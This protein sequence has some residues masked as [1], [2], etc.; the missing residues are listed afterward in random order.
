[1]KLGNMRDY[2]AE[3]TDLPE[4]AIE[5]KFNWPNPKTKKMETLS[6]AEIHKHTLSELRLL[7]DRR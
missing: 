3:A 6:E 5:I 1:M 7:W 4:A 2:V